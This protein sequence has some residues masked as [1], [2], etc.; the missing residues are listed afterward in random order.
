VHGC[1][2]QRH[3]LF[4]ILNNDSGRYASVDPLSRI[5]HRHIGNFPEPS[6]CK[7]PHFWT[8][9]IRQS[10]AVRRQFAHLLEGGEGDITVALSRWGSVRCPM[11]ASLD[12]PR[13]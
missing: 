5:S 12:R 11:L 8:F 9:A 4:G 1:E 7:P 3:E 10:V 2:R 13:N 6:A